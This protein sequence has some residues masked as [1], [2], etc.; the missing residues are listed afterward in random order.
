MLEP[1]EYFMP[2]S[3]SDV[4]RRTLRS[5][6]TKPGWNHLEVRTLRGVLSA[7]RKGPRRD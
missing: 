1:T 6:L 3:K 2:D 7:L 5:L 4:T